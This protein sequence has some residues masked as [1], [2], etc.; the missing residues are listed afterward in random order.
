M[1]HSPNTY[2]YSY[3]LIH[4]LQMAVLLYAYPAFTWQ[5]PTHL[6]YVNTIFLL[7]LNRVSDHCK[8]SKAQNH[9]I[10]RKNNPL[11][12]TNWELYRVM[13]RVP[14]L[15]II[16]WITIRFSTS[17]SASDEDSPWAGAI[18]RDSTPSFSARRRSLSAFLWCSSYSK[19]YILIK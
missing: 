7:S 14:I 4:S 8:K 2:S 9:I 1:G 3:I 15:N 5:A 17:A 16:L 10:T 13:S 12:C 11:C 6:S 18:R 19:I